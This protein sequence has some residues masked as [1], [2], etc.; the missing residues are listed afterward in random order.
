MTN[1]EQAPALCR[2]PVRGLVAVVERTSI[3]VADLAVSPKG[4]Q[5]HR[6]V[7]CLNGPDDL[8]W[9]DQDPDSVAAALARI[10]RE[11]G[12]SSKLACVG[13]PDAAFSTA[14]GPL[15]RTTAAATAALVVRRV[16]QEAI[17]PQADL[18]ADHLVVRPRGDARA[19][20][21]AYVSWCERA[22]MEGFA[23][24]FRRH[25]LQVARVTPPSVALLDLFGRTRPADEARFELLV[26]YSYP[27]LVI[28]VHE[29]RDPVYLR[30]LTDVMS[31]STDGVTGTVLREVLN[32]V[33]YTIENHQGRMVERVSHAGLPAAD[34]RRFEARLRDSANIPAE[35]LSIPV[36]GAGEVPAEASA[37]AIALL[38]QGASPP[39]ADVHPMDLLPARER[40]ASRLLVGL[41]LLAG[42]SVVAA[43]T[44]LAFAREVAS[45]AAGEIEALE[46][47]FADLAGDAGERTA[48]LE[49]A[50][51]VQPREATLARL[52]AGAGNPVQP[53]LETLL[54]VPQ[55]ATLVAACLER[56]C[57]AGAGPA[58]LD[59]KL[60]GDFSGAAGATSQRALTEA[61]A[62]R[63]WC[64]ALQV[65]QGSLRT[66][67]GGEAMAESLGLGLQ[68]R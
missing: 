66:A 7:A 6:F 37:T 43:V 24:S 58:R 8:V 10:L 21:P 39:G 33:A 35:A 49:Q 55:E 34:A 59:L 50:A 29:G 30:V 27:S 1:P 31:D 17:A 15:P 61:L 45:A 62:G 57:A 4:V 48:G 51:L 28:G 14:L 2:R 11:Q 18:L 41:A 40:R 46:R 67:L 42:L 56:P 38:V 64:A 9:F 22:L 26:R 20:R 12:L 54:L 65:T 60:S 13:L 5:V 25:G 16:R 32:T 44:S 23:A 3:T 36:T 68:L 47:E 53:L 52:G 63:P 19:P